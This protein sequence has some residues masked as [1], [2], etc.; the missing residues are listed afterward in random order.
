M[1]VYCIFV[2]KKFRIYVATLFTCV[3]ESYYFFI[4]AREFV[5]VGRIP[6]Q[7]DLQR[8]NITAIFA[9]GKIHELD[10]LIRFVTCHFVPESSL[11]SLEQFIQST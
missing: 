3:K 9:R 2:E 8:V 1:H 10:R 6:S 4:G 5:L 11:N 7:N